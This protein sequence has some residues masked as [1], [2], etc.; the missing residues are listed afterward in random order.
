VLVDVHRLGDD[1]RLTYEPAD[2]AG[3]AA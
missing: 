3:E 1:V 2:R